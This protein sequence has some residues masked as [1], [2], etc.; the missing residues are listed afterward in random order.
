MPNLYGQDLDNL[1][2]K[3]LEGNILLASSEAP[4]KNEKGEKRPKEEYKPA[5]KTIPFW[6]KELMGEEYRGPLPFGVAINFL[7]INQELA[8]EEIVRTVVNSPK[9]LIISSPVHAISNTFSG[10]IRPDA[11][12]LPFL[13]LYGVIGGGGG[14][15]KVKIDTMVD[16]DSTKLGPLDLDLNF[17][18]S[19]FGI[20]AIFIGNI[21]KFFALVDLD[22]IYSKLNIGDSSI[23]TFRF[24]PKIGYLIKKK[25]SSGGGAIWVGTSYNNMRFKFVGIQGP[26]DADDKKISYSFIMGNKKPW[27]FIFGGAWEFNPRWG[28][29]MELGVGNRKQF[30]IAA[31]YRF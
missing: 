28:L 20:G 27:N 10:V 13:N 30:D 12:I 3:F 1:L 4:V 2:P 5:T 17:A 18:G 24:S 31:K 7:Y 9:A 23:N 14:K 29:L 25:K 15:V 26:I 19:L 22:Y 11:W 8:V 21:K 6:Q 16:I